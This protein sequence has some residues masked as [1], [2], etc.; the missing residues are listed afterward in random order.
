[1]SSD[2]CTRMRPLYST[3]PSLR[4]RFIK[5]LTRERV[6]PDHLGEGFL[7][8]C[9]DEHLGLAWFTELGHEQEDARRGVFHWS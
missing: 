1:M 9:G 8:D 3:N 7:G 2:L 4:K 5:K 6:V